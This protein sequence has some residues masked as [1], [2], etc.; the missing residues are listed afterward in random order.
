MKEN[1]SECIGVEV[2]SKCTTYQ[3]HSVNTSVDAPN[4]VHP[5][6][7]APCFQAMA[8]VAREMLKK[9]LC[10]LMKAQSL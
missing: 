10:Q 8:H 1:E 2:G 5:V 7:L 6:P 4:P 3:Q 9:E